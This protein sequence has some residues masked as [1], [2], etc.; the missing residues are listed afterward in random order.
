[1]DG[2]QPGAPP[3]ERN[4]D[5]LPPEDRKVAFRLAQFNRRGRHAFWSVRRHGGTEAE[6]LAAARRTLPR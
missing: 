3:P 1:M 5:T 4:D 2:P 6:A